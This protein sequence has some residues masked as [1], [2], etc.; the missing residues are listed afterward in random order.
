MEDV[1]DG[2]IVLKGADDENQRGEKNGGKSGDAGAT[3]GLAQTLGALGSIA[4]MEL[5]SEGARP[6]RGISPAT[7]GCFWKASAINPARKQ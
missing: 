3:G 5:G 6:E 2:E 1:S 7:A 4:A